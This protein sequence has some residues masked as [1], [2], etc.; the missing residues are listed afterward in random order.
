MEVADKTT[1][2]VRGRKK[3]SIGK[4][5]NL[6]KYPPPFVTEIKLLKEVQSLEPL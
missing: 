1:E 4:E 2:S 3:G 5:C 6:E